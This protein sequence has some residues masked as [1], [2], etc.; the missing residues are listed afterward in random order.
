LYL[1]AEI[2]NSV[3]EF[4][5]PVTFK[6]PV[7]EADPVNGNAAPPPPAFRANE[8]VSAKEAVVENEEDRDV[9]ALDAEVA[10]E[11]LTAEEAVKA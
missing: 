11:E 8:A 4:I 5:D 3:V 7:T 1:E 10:Q 9:I 2:F 6:L